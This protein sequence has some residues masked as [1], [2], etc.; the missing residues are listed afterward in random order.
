[1]N[2][3]SGLSSTR[4]ASVEQQ[5]LPGLLLPVPVPVAAVPKPV[6][7]PKPPAK[8]V[9]TEP[10]RRVLC[11]VPED[12]AVD[13]YMLVWAHEHGFTD[14]EVEHETEHF[15][16]HAEATD[17]RLKSWTAGWR[18]WM[19]KAMEIRPRRPYVAPVRQTAAMRSDDV[20]RSVF[21][22]KGPIYDAEAR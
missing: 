5:S 18:Q 8:V 17:R 4:P 6:P 20:F 10:K 11:A 7:E 16:A 2:K 15:L 14:G 22:P 9:A 19:L 13:A 12:F 3:V 21:G 1:V